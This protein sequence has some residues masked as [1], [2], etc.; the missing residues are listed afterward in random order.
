ME[1]LMTRRAS[2]TLIGVLSVTSIIGL[3]AYAIAHHKAAAPKHG[4][5]A[6]SATAGSKGTV[7]LMAVDEKESATPTT[8]PSQPESLAEKRPEPKIEVT[9]VEKTDPAK[10]KAQFAMAVAKSSVGGALADGKAKIASGDLL[11]GRKLLNDALIGGQLSE[12]DA[13]EAKKLIADAN[14]TIVFSSRSFNDDPWGG[15][16]TVAPGELLQKI[17]FKNAVTSDLLLRINGIPDARRLKAGAT[18][19]VVQGPFHA[20][21]TKHAFNMDLYLGAPGEKGAQYVLSYPVGLG[22]DDSTPTGSWIVE[23]RVPNP[24]YY[25]PRGEGV[26][27]AGDPKNPLGKYWIALTGTDGNAVG[28]QSYGIHGTID[29]DSI[30]KQASLGCIR[31]RNEDV[32]LVYELLVAGKSTVVVKD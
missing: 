17:A 2:R 19:K 15:S 21:V 13:A 16:H 7:T 20:V 27:E 18:I 9:P 14:K 22:R 26:I 3:S 12:S 5:T 23:Q 8:K 11:A 25:S 32:A 29:P 6:V 30:G 1:V 31:M 10:E 24:K 4:D 28:K